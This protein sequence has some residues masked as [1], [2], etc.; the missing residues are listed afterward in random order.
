MIDKCRYLNY[1]IHIVKQID[2]VEE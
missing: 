1:T 2:Y